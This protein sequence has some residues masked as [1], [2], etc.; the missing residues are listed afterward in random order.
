MVAAATTQAPKG[1]NQFLAA[2]RW[3]ESGSPQGNYTEPNGDGAYQIIPSTWRG[4]ATDSGYGKY[5]NMPA[6]TV[7][8]AVQD[9]VAKWA[10]L[11]YFNGNAGSNYYKVALDWNGGVPYVVPN[12]VLGDT[13]VY[14]DS[15]MSHF[16]AING[17]K[18]PPGSTGSLTQTELG[19]AGTAALQNAPIGKGC[20]I[21]LP[22]VGCVDD[23]VL[24][25]PMV[26]LGVVGMIV[27]AAFLAVGVASSNKTAHAVVG[28][29]S[30]VAKVV[31]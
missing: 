24:W 31:R 23:I 9:A 3:Q 27:G 20:Y 26:A 15:V 4:W 6:S 7:P 8:K 21:K 18:I 2:L 16:A 1:L 30:K 12:P 29:V 22:V 11:Q 19:D 17:G 13:G 25:G 28:A 14:A 5:A 10:V